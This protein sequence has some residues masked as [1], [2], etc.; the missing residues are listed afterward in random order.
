MTS[1]SAKSKYLKLKMEITKHGTKK[2]RL[3]FNFLNFFLSRKWSKTCPTCRVEL[4]INNIQHSSLAAS[5]I[6]L[7]EIACI[8]QV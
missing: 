6:D 2:C 3:N 8:N 1:V 4:D 7:L 5:I